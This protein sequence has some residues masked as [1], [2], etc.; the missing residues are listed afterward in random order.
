MYAQL[1]VLH[2]L[3][4]LAQLEPSQTEEDSMM[5]CIAICVPRVS[6]AQKLPPLPK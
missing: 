5:S 3:K 1:V 6:T 2:K 4:S